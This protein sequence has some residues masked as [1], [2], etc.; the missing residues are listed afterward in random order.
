MNNIV[1]SRDIEQAR[2][3]Y[4]AGDIQ[5]SIKAHQL[6]PHKENHK[7]GGDVLKSAVFGS[8]DAIITIFTAV[9]GAE[10]SNLGALVVLIIGI[11]SIISDAL[12]MAF[13]DYLS[14]RAEMEFAKNE[15]KREY[16]EVEN[17][18]E[19]EKEEMVQIYI[20]KGMAKEDA[21]SMI[22]I[23]SKYKDAWVDV[24]MV[25]ELGIVMGD[26]SAAKNAVV[27]LISFIIGGLIPVLPYAIGYGAGV[28]L[29]T[30]VPFALCIVLSAIEM[31]FVGV[32]KSR[33]SGQKWIWSGIEALIIGV[34]AGAASY[35]VGRALKPLTHGHVA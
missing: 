15:R 6:D 32:L 7:T 33:F 10:G 17:N 18:P 31:F 19:G 26:D 8:F 9:A 12:A 27:T 24:M 5:A 16:W 29:D 35:G 34:I 3:A 4:K 25:E 21:E 28:R 22:D 20:N 11:V 1:L 2:D 30:T 13:G 23:L 14:S